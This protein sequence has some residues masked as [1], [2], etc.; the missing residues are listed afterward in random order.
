VL[1]GGRLDVLKKVNMLLAFIAMGAGFYHFFSNHL[2]FSSNSILSC[3]A[4][5]FLL[6]G[7]EKVKEKEGDQK[8]G[9]VY[10]AAALVMTLGLMK[11]FVPFI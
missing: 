3:L 6:F 9:Y 5:M 10:L 11:E 2:D 4:I 1:G 7:I 8:L